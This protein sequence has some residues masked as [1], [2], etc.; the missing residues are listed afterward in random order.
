MDQLSSVGSHYFL[1]L[2]ILVFSRGMDFLST[3]IATPTLSLEANPIA[4]RLGWK[5]GL[6]LNAVIC[7]AV[8]L[9]PLPAIVIATTS[10]LVA[11]R[12]FQHAW[13]MR[14][15]GEYQYR[16]W[17]VFQM[18]QASLGL[19]LFCLLAQGVLTA[20]VG[21][22]VMVFSHHAVTFA[23]GVGILT[24]SLA[25]TFYTLLSLRKVRQRRQDPYY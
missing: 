19:Y 10:V 18:A 24:Y 20:L 25:A 17:M 16:Q 12:N 3:W 11:A 4:K 14:S 7:F 6:I 23:V 13:L 2:L 5:F 8:A 21:I 1:T 22:T 9:W 15:L